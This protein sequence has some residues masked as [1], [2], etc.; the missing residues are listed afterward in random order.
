MAVDPIR[1]PNPVSDGTLPEYP[2]GD[3]LEPERYAEYT[4]ALWDEQEEALRPLHQVWLQNLLFLSGRQW[5]KYNPVTGTFGPARVPP[6]RKQP[7][8]NL[9]LAFFRTF[10]AKATRVRPAWQVVPA[11]TDPEDVKAAELADDVLQAKWLELK[12]SRTLRQ[13]VAWTIATGNAFLYPY[14]NSDTGKLEP[15]YIEREIPKYDENGMMIGTELA[16]VPADENGDPILTADGTYDL[17]AEPALVDRGDVGVRVYSPFQVRVNAD[18]ETDEDVTVVMIA[19]AVTLRELYDTYPEL[20]GE[21]I[22]EDTSE[23]EDYDRLFM[24]I[25]GGADTHITSGA[26]TRD[27]E[28]P[29]ALVIHYHERPSPRYP[30]GRYWVVA[31]RNALLVPPGPLPEGVWPPVVHLMDIPFPGRYYA[32]A[33]MESIVGLNRE[34]NEIN[35]A[36]A[37]HHERMLKGKWIVEK[38]TGVKKGMITDAPAEVIQVNTG[39]INGIKQIDLKPLPEAVYR[40]RDRVLNDF[41]LVSGIHKISMGRPPPGVTAGVA[42]LQLQEADDTDLGPFLAMLEESVAQLAGAILQIIKERYD[43]ERLIHVVGPDRRF[44]ARSFK[45]ADLAGAVDVVPV[46]ESSFPWS[47]TARQSMLLEMAA[48]LPALFVDP[49]TG[50]FDAARFAR[51]LPIGGLESL[52]AHQDLDVQ[53]AMREEEMFEHYGIESNELP[54]V[55]FWQDHEVHYRQHTRVL[56]SARFRDWPPENQALFLA[57]VQEHD[58]RRAIARATGT[59]SPAAQEMAQ[60]AG[61]GQAV[62]STAN[63][64]APIP[65]MIAEITGLRPP[66][67]PRGRDAPAPPPGE[68]GPL[69]GIGDPLA[70][71]GR[72]F[73][74]PE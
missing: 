32:M 9:S 54:Q 20:A 62:G 7:V 49:E 69:Q 6:W 16:L 13:A 30:Q 48:R 45:G 64:D 33:T 37:E 4:R 29:K 15:L 58:R 72:V 42:F 19:E 63:P 35:G 8:S 74:G 25:T 68:P 50:Q 71:A 67:A 47:K 14:W 56:K 46:A 11:S 5:W 22:A 53:E 61:A 43:E 1:L 41:E 26:D 51:L 12:L 3:D 70:E 18:A 27:R 28:I 60:A 52:T 38:G 31:G 66:A 24:A 65:E 23:L 2:D 39:F 59:T 73:P 17:N 55:E 40:E 21:I 44:L 57:H 34:Y 36:I 10:L